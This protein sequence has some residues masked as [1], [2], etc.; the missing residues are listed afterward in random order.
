[1]VVRVLGGRPILSYVASAE[2]IGIR[3]RGEITGETP[4]VRYEE[5]IVLKPDNTYLL[6]QRVQ[7]S[8]KV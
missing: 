1:M 6:G 5:A 2:D 4:I 7:R 8:N 3:V